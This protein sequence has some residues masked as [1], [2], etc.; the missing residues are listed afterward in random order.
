MAL[1]LAMGTAPS[2]AVYAVSSGLPYSKFS[3]AVAKTERCSSGAMRLKVSP[4][5]GHIG[6]VLE[7]SAGYTRVAVVGGMATIFEAES[8]RGWSAYD[9]LSTASGGPDWD[10]LGSVRV[11]PGVKMALPG[12]FD[13]V[14]VRMPDAPPGTYRL[15]RHYY[16]ASGRQQ[17]TK[18]PSNGVNLCGSVTIM[19]TGKAFVPVGE[20]IIQVNPSSALAADTMVHITLNGF[21]PSSVVWLSQ[22]AF[23]RLATST[24]CAGLEPPDRVRLGRTG[25]G[26]ANMRVQAT[27]SALPGPAATKY[28]CMSNCIL[29]ATM[30]KG[31]ASAGTPITLRATGAS[32]V[33][34]EV[35]E[36]PIPGRVLGVPGRVSFRS[37]GPGPVKVFKTRTTPDGE[38]SLFLPPGRYGVTGESG[39]V[40]RNRKAVTCHGNPSSITVVNNIPGPEV[41]VFCQ[42]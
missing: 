22:C 30:G 15:V 8:P 14:Y 3:L 10:G 26:T 16:P 1:F 5:D 2:S 17:T 41:D 32:G 31:F 35:Q 40:E 4:E 19:P 12:V 39:L 33:L 27:A 23:S 6:E 21:A 42:A 37:I 36:P 13:P 34:G 11:T 29:V 18:I 7:L 25:S 38:F 9:Y 28:P 20:P 24:G